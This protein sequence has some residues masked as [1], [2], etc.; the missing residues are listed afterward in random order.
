LNELA[1]L[2]ADGTITAWIRTSVVLD[3]AAQM[4]ERLRNGGLRGKVVIQL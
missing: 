2:L 3:D 4:L 1:R